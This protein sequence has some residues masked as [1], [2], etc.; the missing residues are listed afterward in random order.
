MR[1]FRCCPIC[2]AESMSIVDQ[3]EQTNIA[4]GILLTLLKNWLVEQFKLCAALK[5]GAVLSRR[6]QDKRRPACRFASRF[7]GEQT[8]VE[9]LRFEVCLC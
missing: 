6:M 1:R 8:P 9:K 7:L 2:S 5:H 3:S 4:A